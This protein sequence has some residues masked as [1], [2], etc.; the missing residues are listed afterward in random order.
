MWRGP[1]DQASRHRA[2]VRRRWPSLLVAGVVVVVVAV[3]AGLLLSARQS[4]TAD[5]QPQAPTE[6]TT[7][8]TTTPA[9][10]P[11]KDPFSVAALSVAKTL[12]GL[13][14]SLSWAVSATSPDLGSQRPVHP[15]L[16]MSPADSSAEHFWVRSFAS[17]QGDS[18]VHAVQAL[19]VM[20]SPEVAE[21]TYSR[22]VE[23]LSSCS[24]GARQVVGYR[25]VSGVGAGGSL[26]TLRFSDDG[27]IRD[28]QVAAFHSG[29]AV[30]LWVVRDSE[31]HP[32]S[33][34]TLVTLAGDS[35]DTL[36]AAAKGPCSRRPYGVTS[37]TPPPTDEL[38]FLAVVDL[39][40]F[41]G[42]THPWVATTPQTVSP[43]P[44]ATE[45]DRADFDAAGARK[46]LSKSF[47]VPDEPRLPAIFGMSETIGTFSSRIKAR[48]FLATVTR[49][50]AACPDRQLSLTVRQSDELPSKRV[51]G[52]V[53]EIELASSERTSLA[54]RIALLRVG[55]TVAQVTFTPTDDIDLNHGAFVRFAGRA[56]E[57]LGQR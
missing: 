35:V 12:S 45:C 36:C 46:V 1:S 29:T 27:D 6:S 54:F 5:D 40:V 33:A 4:E 48:Q 15:C 8:V 23:S 7:P 51:S 30:V 11:P 43:N 19:E 14:Q 39:P 28:E 38:G 50:V 26:F 56:A 21:A 22:L 55:S 53:W 17:G 16:T 20:R 9:P 32:V 13:D 42:V 34:R 49:A 10:S 25:V 24:P 57:R 3:V 52:R 44:A 37:R 47:V 31:A 18:S 2:G 41:A